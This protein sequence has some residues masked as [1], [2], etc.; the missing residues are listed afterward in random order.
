MTATNMTALPAWA[1]EASRTVVADGIRTHCFDLGSGPVLILIH[2]G[3]PGA[4]SWGNWQGT[5]RAYARHFRVIAYDMPGFGR[6]DKPSPDRYPYDQD[7]RNRHLIALIETLDLAAVRLIGNSMGGATSLG[8]CIQR[9]DLVDKLVL[10]G[11]AGLAVNNPDPGF[12]EQLRTYD[13]TLEGMRMIMRV[14]T[15]PR[16]QIDE[17]ALHYRHALMQDPA[18][19]LAISSIVRSDLTYAEEKIAAVKTPTLVVAGKKDKIAIPAR[20]R[21]Y[22]ELLENSWGFFVPHVGHWVMLEATDLFVQIT[23]Q[24]LTQPWERTVMQPCMNG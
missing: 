22:L 5:L 9:P 17:D 11:A 3:G 19:R 15:G 16:Y 8:I 2:G 24:F 6:S 14:M 21:R 7:S 20:N 1:V 18:A 4:D 12:K 13:N 10:M 23:T